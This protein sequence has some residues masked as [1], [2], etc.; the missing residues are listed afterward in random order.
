[1]NYAIYE[2][3]PYNHVWKIYERLTYAESCEI[4]CWIMSECFQMCL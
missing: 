4:L 1:M 3:E 2:Y